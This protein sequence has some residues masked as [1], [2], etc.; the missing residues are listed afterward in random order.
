LEAA[1]QSSISYVAS[2]AASA[3][4][5]VTFDTTIEGFPETEL[6]VWILGKSYSAIHG[7]VKSVEKT[8]FYRIY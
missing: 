1:S 7:K 5:M 8:Q 4:S 2:M 3:A 6:P